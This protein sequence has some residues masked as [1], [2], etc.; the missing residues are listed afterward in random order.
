MDG[1]TSTSSSSS[2]YSRASSRVSSRGGLSR[3]FLSEPGGPHVGELLLL[4][5]VDDHVVA[6]GVFGDDHPLVDVVAG[7]D[8][9]GAALLEV[10]EG[11]GDGLA[12]APG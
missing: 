2:M 10:V 4:A 11:E 1:V 5:R 9:H 6:A 7:L 12:R 8:E 3:M